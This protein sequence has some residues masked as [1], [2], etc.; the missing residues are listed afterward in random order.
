MEENR[1]IQEIEFNEET[2]MGQEFQNPALLTKAYK[3]IG[4]TRDIVELDTRYLN[5]QIDHTKTEWPLPP[6]EKQLS[7]IKGKL[8]QLSK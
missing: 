1:I 2:I 3:T 6:L 5:A 7:S 4:Q 8:F